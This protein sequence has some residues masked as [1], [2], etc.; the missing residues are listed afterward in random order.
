MARPFLLKVLNAAPKDG[1]TQLAANTTAKVALV[2]KGA[3]A[4]PPAPATIAKHGF[5]GFA[6]T[7]KL[8]TKTGLQVPNDAPIAGE[9]LLVVTDD[10]GKH[11]PVVQRLTVTEKKGFLVVSAGWAGGTSGAQGP[12]FQ[13]ATVDILNRGDTPKGGRKVQPALQTVVTVR[14]FARAEFILMSG[15]ETHENDRFSWRVLPEGRRNILGRRGT[16]GPGDLVTMLHCESRERIT[17][18]KA[19]KPGKW[20]V[21]DTFVKS[22][23]KRTTNDFKLEPKDATKDIGILDLYACM[24]ESGTVAPQSVKEVSIFSHAFV[25]GPVLFNTDQDEGGNDFTGRPE[26]NPLDIDGRGK[27]WDAAHTMRALPG[28]KNA[29]ASDGFFKVWGCNAF[30]VLHSIIDASVAKLAPG[31]D[32]TKLFTANITFTS[33]RQIGH[34]LKKVDVSERTTIRHLLLR[35]V[36]DQFNQSY[37]LAAERFLGRPAFGALPGTGSIHPQDT[38][39]KDFRMEIEPGNDRVLTFYQ[40]ELG[41]TL[42]DDGR[43]G[44]YA[45]LAPKL[46]GVPRPAFN[47]ERFQMYTVIRKAPTPTKPDLSRLIVASGAII[48]SAPKNDGTAYTSQRADGLVTP[49]KKGMLFVVELADVASVDDI[50]AGRRIIL[51]PSSTRDTGLYMQEDGRLFR[52]QRAPGAPLSSFK[53]D[54]TTVKIGSKPLVGGVLH[55]APGDFPF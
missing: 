24:H 2:E 22:G 37:T 14:L 16:I 21:I 15:I 42:D 5:R 11:S 19:N 10:G 36:Q 49:G 33:V 28:V 47:V 54:T 13:A 1:K 35:D 4:S 43:Y 23:T 40:H 20:L 45:A 30:R 9:F 12:N 51:A 7:H 26:R 32:E 55:Q 29:L 46:A 38:K 48:L 44:R 53:V 34:D 6:A 3:A 50:A 8:D 31:F 52:M 41:A 17:M 18:V 27:D 25:Q 39:T